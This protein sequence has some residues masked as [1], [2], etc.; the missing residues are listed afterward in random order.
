MSK[1]KRR[2][3]IIKQLISGKDEEYN[4]S[5]ELDKQYE[6]VV[7][8]YAYG[9]PNYTQNNNLVFISPLKINNTEHFP[10]NFDSALL[11]PIDHNDDFTKIS[12]EAAGSRLEVTVKD[13]NVVATPYYFTI[14]LILE[15]GDGD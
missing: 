9:N 5:V 4:I 11:Y 12:E 14:L 1:R 2:Y 15:N 10:E 8:I 13:Q 6:R 7:R 3:Q